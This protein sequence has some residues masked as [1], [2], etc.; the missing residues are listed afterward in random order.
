MVGVICMAF[1]ATSVC[2]V[3]A[4]SAI[5]I[6]AL[7]A[8]AYYTKADFTGMGAYIL[9]AIL[10][11]VLLG[12]IGIF[13]PMGSHVHELIAGLGAMIFGFIIVYDTQ[14]IFGESSFGGSKNYQFT[15]DMYAFA[16][17]ELYL[18]FINF[19]IYM[20]QLFGRRD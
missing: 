10:G 4:I 18:D 11:L 12:A 2:L 16:A 3:F 13:F 17:F 15:I 7:T 8:Y 14:M 19:F 5:I 20:L 1:T 9:V 6:L